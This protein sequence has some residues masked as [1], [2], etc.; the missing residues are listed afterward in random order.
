M[1]KKEFDINFGVGI[2]AERIR[3]VVMVM[4]WILGWASPGAACDDDCVQNLLAMNRRIDVLE[5]YRDSDEM[6]KLKIRHME[7]I[8]EYRKKAGSRAL[9]YDIMAGRV[10]NMQARNAA[11]YGYGGHWDL[12]GNAPFLRYGLNGGVDHVSEN[13]Y[14]KTTIYRNY[15]GKEVPCGMREAD[16]ITAD[17]KEATEAFLNEGPDGKHRENVLRDAHNYIGIGFYCE[18][19][20]SGGNAEFRVR[21]YEEYVNRYI[22]FDPL[23]L[24]VSAG[25]AASVA[26][27]VIPEDT[28][29]YI[30]AVYYIDEPKPLTPEQINNMPGYYRDYSGKQVLLLGPSEIE[31][32]KTMRRFSFE[33]RPAEKGYYYVQTLLRRGLSSIP[34]DS[35]SSEKIM[36]P[37]DFIYASGII[38][39]AE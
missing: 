31:F 2:A 4:A 29:V 27:T 18:P 22:S 32:N 9:E 25:D 11:S 15:K 20:I 1:V 35:Y 28:G 36:A 8:N 30:I 38:L 37:E 23:R 12:D 24:S 17:M 14:E 6:L 33:F 13:A 21:Y 34:Y 5:E 19:V 39:H 3:T 26:G 16:K 7:L 10:A